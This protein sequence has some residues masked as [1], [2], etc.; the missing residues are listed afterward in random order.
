MRWSSGAARGSRYVTTVVIAYTTDTISA[1]RASTAAAVLS[2]E[3][4]LGI[5]TAKTKHVVSRFVLGEG[6]KPAEGMITATLLAR[7]AKW[8][9]AGAAVFC[10]YEAGPTGFA[11]ARQ[12]VALGGE[13]A[14]GGGGNLARGRDRRAAE[15]CC[16]AAVLPAV[17]QDHAT[18]RRLSAPKRNPHRRSRPAAVTRDGLVQP[19]SRFALRRSR[20]LGARH[21]FAARGPNDERPVD[22]R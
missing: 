7:V 14:A 9:K 8:R 10:V 20:T 18:P 19:A 16:A 2:E 22:C 3:V 11:L 13:S 4:F 5:D 15:S 21:L 17:A 6:A 12:L 1:A